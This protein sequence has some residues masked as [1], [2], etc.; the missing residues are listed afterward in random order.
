MHHVDDHRNGSQAGP[1]DV[2]RLAVVRHGPVLD[3]G[4]AFLVGDAFG[5]QSAVHLHGSAQFTGARV[6]EVRQR[7]L[8]HRRFSFTVWSSNTD[9]SIQDL[10]NEHCVHPQDLQCEVDVEGVERVAFGVDAVVGTVGS[11]D[12]Q[13]GRDAPRR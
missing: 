12:R 11:L 4:A 10:R 8:G 1:R 9:V 7:G 6:R 13:H 3:Q 5:Q 2:A